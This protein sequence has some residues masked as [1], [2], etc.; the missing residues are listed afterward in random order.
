M[1]F[2]V[3]FTGTTGAPYTLWSST[4]VSLTP[5]ETTWTQVTTGT[6]SGGTDSYTDPAGG[7][8]AQEFYIITSP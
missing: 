3:F 1:G 7:T 8:S 6:F 2:E 5:V 4:D